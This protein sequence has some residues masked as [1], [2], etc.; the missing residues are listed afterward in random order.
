MPPDLFG[1][2][3]MKRR[4]GRVGEG[5]P[6]HE[7]RRRVGRRANVRFRLEIDRRAPIQP[8]RFSFDRSAHKKFCM[9]ESSRAGDGL[10]SRALMLPFRVLNPPVVETPFSTVG[11]PP[12]YLTVPVLL[13][14]IGTMIG[15][16]VYCR[17]NDVGWDCY[18]P[19]HLIC[20]GQGT[21]GLKEAVIVGA[22]VALGGLSLVA[23][24]HAVTAEKRAGLVH[25]YVYRYAMT[26]PVWA[27]LSYEVVKTKLPQWDLEFVRGARAAVDTG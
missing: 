16:F 6:A 4:R 14:S 25:A 17:V 9:S 23:A 20:P 19:G 12:T 7:R 18:L 13:L 10:L 26:F 5:L 1:T 22:I 2:A 24:Y 21:Q 11:I 15:G 8:G 27:L 3:L